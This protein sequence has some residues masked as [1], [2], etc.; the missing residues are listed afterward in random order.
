M[1]FNG[2][3]YFYDIWIVVVE[4]KFGFELYIVIWNLVK[5]CFYNDEDIFDDGW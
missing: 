2:L 1:I 3:N 4:G 5:E